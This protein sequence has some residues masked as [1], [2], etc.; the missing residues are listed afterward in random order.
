VRKIIAIGGTGQL[1]AFHY[2]QLYLLGVVQ[3]P[4]ELVV[5]DTDDINKGLLRLGEYLDLLRT[6]EGR[7]TS[8]GF[9]L[10]TL[11]T[12]KINVP[13]ASAAEALSGLKNVPSDHPVRAFFDRESVQQPLKQGLYAR[14]AL[15]SVISRAQIGDALLMPAKDSTTVAVGSIIGGTSGGLL[16][17]IVDR[18]KVL[19]YT[20]EIKSRLR[21]VLFAQY[22]DPDEG[23]GIEAV[24]L[25]SNEL[26]VMKTAREA[27]DQLDLFYIVG[28]PDTPRIKRLTD[29]ENEPNLP[30]PELEEHPVWSG[31]TALDFLSL[32]T[33]MPF[34][35][36][37]ED[38]EVTNFQRSFTLAMARQRLTLAVCIVRALLNH[39]VLERMVGEP[40]IPLIW[41][42][43]LP[44]L[45]SHYWRVAARAAGGWDRVEAF[46][47]DVQ[48]AVEAL[49]KGDGNTWGVGDVLPTVATAHA[50]SPHRFSEVRWPEIDTKPIT[51]VRLFL[52]AA[53][54]ARRAAAVL[55]F[56]SLRTGV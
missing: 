46:A 17:P 15:S 22:F 27:L 25:Q 34:R 56:W 13:D 24:R 52:S 12:Q 29:R 42:K 14:P 37:F 53:E 2:L 8:F 7:S 32:D 40:W 51:D 9:E 30:W 36:R 47:T 19:A 6:M 21:A 23:R 18:M 5:V 50:V 20:H 16:E 49:W 43:R 54:T 26:L 35:D 44:A 38:R 1:I 3:E 41:G 39:R 55:L 11:V 31:L 33:V 48:A 45:V 10:P 4:F 28:G